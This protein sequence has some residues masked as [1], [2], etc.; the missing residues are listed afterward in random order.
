MKRRRLLASGSFVVAT[1][2]AGCIGRVAPRPET[3]DD[4][5]HLTSD[6]WGEAGGPRPDARTFEDEA[7][8]LER[9]MGPAAEAFEAFVTA[10]DFRSSY[11]ALV[12]GVD[13]GG[14]TRLTLRSAER[15]G[16]TLH[17][18]IDEWPPEDSEP[19]PAAIFVHSLATRRPRDGG[20]V[21]E[22]VDARVIRAEDR[23][24]LNEVGERI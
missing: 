14:G 18:V 4:T 21:P 3:D 6:V 23:S 11:V 7:T 19:R 10:T 1:G 16:D 13:V 15:D 17:L 2:L 12:Q 5:L 20:G 24:L 8:A 22:N 9:A